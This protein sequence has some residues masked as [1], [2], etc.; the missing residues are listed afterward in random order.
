MAV[1]RQGRER[2]VEQSNAAAVAEVSHGQASV[3]EHAVELRQKIDSRS[4]KVG[5]VGL[6]YVGLPLALTFAERAFLVLGFDV[7][8]AKI[9]ALG[10]GRNY[11]KHLHPDRLA[12]SNASGNFGSFSNRRLIPAP[13]TSWSV[14]FSRAPD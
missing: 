11:I 4:A 7:D 13:R 14:G 10:A 9:E 12:R 5:I 6:G 8:R 1:E 2:E 3:T